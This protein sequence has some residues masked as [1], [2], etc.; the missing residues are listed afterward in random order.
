MFVNINCRLRDVA[1]WLKHSTR[2]GR[3]CLLILIA[4][5][6]RSGECVRGPVVEALG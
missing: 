6:E 2:E 3:N 4:V 5:L 1:Q